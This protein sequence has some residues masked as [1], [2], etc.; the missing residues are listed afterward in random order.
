MTMATVVQD[1]AAR[2]LKPWTLKETI[3]NVLQDAGPGGLTLKE[4]VQRIKKN[5]W[6]DW[7]ND[8]SGYYSVAS[9]CRCHTYRDIFAHVASGTWAL[10]DL[11]DDDFTPYVKPVK[12]MTLKE[13]IINV[14]QDAGQ[15][16][17]TLKEMVQRIKKKFSWDWKNDRQCYYSVSERCYRCGDVFVKHSPGVYALRSLQGG[18]GEGEKSSKTLANAKASDAERTASAAKRTRQAASESE[19]ESNPITVKKKTKKEAEEE[20]TEDPQGYVVHEDCIIDSDSDEDFILEPVPTMCDHSRA[21]LEEPQSH[22]VPVEEKRLLLYTDEQKEAAD[23]R[24]ERALEQARAGRRSAG[25]PK[26]IGKASSSESEE[27]SFSDL[28]FI[29]VTDFTMAELK[30]IAEAENKRIGILSHTV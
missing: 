16:G 11:Q 4:L 30:A 8:K 29:T 21:G 15:G 13:C 9:V 28:T 2:Y 27:R 18:E 17:L 14:L 20:L 12:P 22:V 25:R 23:K 7:E 6:W 1:V 10:W 19:D 24:L 26:E 5:K 3:I